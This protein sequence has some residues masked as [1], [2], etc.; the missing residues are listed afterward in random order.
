MSG[1]FEFTQINGNREKVKLKGSVGASEI[2]LTTDGPIG[3][4]SDFIFSVRRSYLQLLFS[5]I[6]LPF[7]PT[8]NDYQIKY[9]YKMNRK[10]EFTLISIGALDQ[11]KLNK[12]INNPTPDQEYILTNI[13]VYEQWSYTIG[14]VYKHY[15]EKSNKTIVLSRN[16]LNNSIYKY[17]ENDESKPRSLDYI[18]QEMENKFRFEV[19]QRVNNYK[20]IYGISSE[21]A[22]YTNSTS[23]LVSIN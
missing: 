8:F 3:E 17:P 13:P 22:K 18:S 6:G 14:G 4:K 16:M 15:D 21:W 12:G 1:V 7:L 10:N 19:S 20:F 9:R 11:F 5:A 2:S 23:R